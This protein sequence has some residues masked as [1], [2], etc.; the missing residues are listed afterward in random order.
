MVDV[1]NSNTGGLGLRTK[2]AG[3]NP[4]VTK[5]FAAAH[6][7]IIFNREKNSPTDDDTGCFPVETIEPFVARTP[8]RFRSN[9]PVRIK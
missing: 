9:S 6:P 7:A 1:L 3:S 4:A 8:D 2:I 5:Q